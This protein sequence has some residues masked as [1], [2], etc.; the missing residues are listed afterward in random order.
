MA[1]SNLNLG[2][3]SG[4]V[5]NVQ[6]AD[7]TTTTSLVLPAING[8]VVVADSNG[9]VG[10]GVSTATLTGAADKAVHIHANTESQIHLTNITTGNTSSDGSVVSVDSSGNLYLYNK[11]N[12][13]TIIGTNNVER[14]RIDSA[15]NIGIGVTPSTSTVPT[16]QSQFN[17]LAGQEESNLNTNAYYSSGVFKYIANGYATSYIQQKT[18]GNH[19]WKVSPLGIAGNAITWTNAMT[20][21]SSGTLSIG[22]TPSAWLYNTYKSIDLG[23]SG[24]ISGYYG[25]ATR[26]VLLSGNAYRNTT[27]NWIYK[28]TQGACL[29]EAANGVFNWLTAPNGTANNTI[30]WTNAMTLD[31]NSSLNILGNVVAGTAGGN[32]AA[33]GSVYNGVF[34][35]NSS[36]YTVLFARTVSDTNPI[37]S[38]AVSGNT[39][40]QILANGNFQSATNSYGSTSDAKLKENVQDA[41]PKLD[42][43]MQVQVRTFNYIGQEDKQ[44][45]VVAQEIEKIF[46]S[47]VY[48][49]KDTKQVEVEKEREVTLEDG[50][51]DVEKYT[52][53]ETVETGEVTKNVKY[54]V[55][56]MMMLKA[57][58]EQNEIIKDLKSRIEILEAK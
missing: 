35:T 24:S 17:M 19:T 48:E 7:G 53:M 44:I 10:I 26:G 5:L 34:A 45:G 47:I 40:A 6:P 1:A 43:L 25:S 3:A 33:P 42:K 15:G 11:E 29:F 39:K 38:G 54:S 27:G 32:Y 51:I 13:N 22:V 31:A 4:G 55:I 37:F 21:D 57:M 52:E 23:D 18:G 2:K 20:L 50:T 28:N 46:P 36:S 14:M 56:Y 9:N 8:T 30:T 58:Q 16:I 12:A 41:S 49:T